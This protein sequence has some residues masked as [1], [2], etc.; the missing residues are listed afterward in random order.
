MMI[1]FS[2]YISKMS[3]GSS[4]AK[5]G[6]E[7]ETGQTEPATKVVQTPSKAIT[8]EGLM[9]YVKDR[10]KKSHNDWM[11]THIQEACNTLIDAINEAIKGA[12]AGPVGSYSITYYVSWKIGGLNLS[13]RQLKEF[14]LDKFA[15]VKFR[16]RNRRPD[17]KDKLT[18][19]PMFDGDGKMYFQVL[20]PYEIAEN[21]IDL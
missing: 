16:I 4:G 12:I 1:F 10:N 17:A 7:A 3:E 21:G 8:E 15:N 5:R 14:V 2:F 19:N 9:R 11:D 20:L 13:M 18:A 6:R